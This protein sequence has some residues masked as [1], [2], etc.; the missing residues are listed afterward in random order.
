MNIKKRKYSIILTHLPVPFILLFQYSWLVS[1]ETPL[2]GFV[3]MLIPVEKTCFYII[4]I[5]SFFTYFL[6]N[7]MVIGLNSDRLQ[8]KGKNFP[9]KKLRI[10]LLFS[11]LGM[12]TTNIYVFKY[13]CDYYII[14][15]GIIILIE[16]ILLIWVIVDSRR[17]H[18]NLKCIWKSS[19]NQGK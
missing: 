8:N 9:E 7:V 2:F 13:W 15:L 3:T 10:A 6:S 11:F 17:Q 19:A 4:N 16:L 1:G 18:I 14:Q 12:L 5:V